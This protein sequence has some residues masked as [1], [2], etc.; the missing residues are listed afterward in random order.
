MK[1]DKCDETQDTRKSLATIRFIVDNPQL[2][3]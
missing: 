1:K 3:C 2:H